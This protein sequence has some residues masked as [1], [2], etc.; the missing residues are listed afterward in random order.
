VVAI[1]ARITA[2][3]SLE[4]ILLNDELISGSSPTSTVC[5]SFSNNSQ[6]LYHSKTSHR[7]RGY[8][9]QDGQVSPNKQKPMIYTCRVNY[10][11]LRSVEALNLVSSTPVGSCA[12]EVS[13]RMERSGKR[14][15]LKHASHSTAVNWLRSYQKNALLGMDSTVN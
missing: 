7:L 5:K 2:S 6:L 11:L 14:T 3:R 12:A 1:A 15:L 10:T 8:A 4:S 13:S 9:K